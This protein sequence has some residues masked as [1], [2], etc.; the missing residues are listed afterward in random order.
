MFIGGCATSLK[1]IQGDYILKK[2]EGILLTKLRSN[3]PFQITLKNSKGDVYKLEQGSPANNTLLV[4]NLMQ[5]KYL[6]HKISW[7]N[8][9][10]T[11]PEKKS[12]SFFIKKG[13]VNYIC[14]FGAYFKN[15]GDSAVTAEMIP[16]LDFVLPVY[17]KQNTYKKFKR[18]FPG[19]AKKYP[20]ASSLVSMC[21]RND[22]KKALELNR[23]L[24]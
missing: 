24:N 8:K 17:S 12:F 19:I 16:G 7:K 21:E 13:K 4:V 5:D 14:D 1:S 22:S 23:L 18:E 6:I 10:V 11:L 20:V 9:E 3:Y 15:K 2:D